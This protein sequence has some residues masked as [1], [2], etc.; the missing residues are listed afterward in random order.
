MTGSGWLVQEVLWFAMHLPLLGVLVV[1]VGTGALLR[2][3]GWPAALLAAASAFGLLS[4]AL[5]TLA[6]S[7]VVVGSYQ[8]W[9]SFSPWIDVIVPTLIVSRALTEGIVVTLLG[10]ALLGAARR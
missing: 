9:W 1:G 2:R 6:W 8:L 5:M 7:A 4:V 3:R 10:I